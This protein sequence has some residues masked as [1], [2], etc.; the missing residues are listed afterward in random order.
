MTAAHLPVLQVVA[1]LLAAPLCVMLRA[2]LAAWLLTCAVAVIAIVIAAI[3]LFTV[4]AG[5]GAVLI[6]ALGGWAAPWGIEYRVDIV[7]AFVLVIITGINLV[8]VLCGRASVMREIP[9]ERVFLFYTGWLLCLTGMLGIAV[10]G[11]VFNVFVFLEIASLASCLLVSLGRDRRCLSAAFRYLLMGSVGATF[12]LIVVGLLYQMTGT[13]N[14]ADLA[15]RLPP[16]AQSRTLQVAFAFLTVG[17]GLKAA[18]F[19]LHF[20][21]PGA[22]AFAPSMAAVFLAG[23]STKASVYIL[24]RF[25]FSVMGAELSFDAMRLHWF[26]LPLALAGIFAASVAAIYQSDVKRLLA[27][28]SVAQVGYMI[29]GVATGSGAGLAAA[30]VHLFNHALMKSALFFVVACMVLRVGGARLADLAGVGKRMP[31]TAAA[32]VVS[33]LS[34]VGFPFTAGFISKWALLAAALDSHGWWLA[35][36]VL[37]S[38]LLAV[39]YMWRVVEAVYCAPKTASAES[40]TVTEAPLP[41]LIG[42]WLLAAANVVFG[43]STELSL[44]IAERA[45]VLLIG[46]AP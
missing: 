17:V 24:L 13:L 31:L 41:L 8:A 10:S 45:A 6:Y 5:D 29:L 35:L 37:A 21:L 7:G 33:G 16:L 38:S 22:Y 42:A 15:A 36:L 46:D 11:D 28:S 26:L 43:L 27:F 19:P 3:L 40:Q 2:P 44:G 4:T 20:W 1:P 9:A 32:L 34:L 30:L 18:V 12:I 14:M 23:T 39:V 25:F